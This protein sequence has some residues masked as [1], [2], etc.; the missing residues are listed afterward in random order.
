MELAI[1]SS[2]AL[3]SG[4]DRPA[5]W[6]WR[7][8]AAILLTA[9]VCC[10][11]LAD[12]MAQ[13]APAASE[14]LAQQAS[15]A[16]VV[17][18]NRPIV[19]FRSAIGSLTPEQRAERVQ[20]RL[21]D[22]DI[23]KL[24][25]EIV[26]ESGALGDVRGVLLLLDGGI[27][28]GITEGD[29]DPEKNE[30][31]EQVAAEATANL[32]EAFAARLEQER[33]P[34]L[35]RGIGLTLGGA[36]FVAALIWLVWRLRSRAG[37]MFDAL[38][39]RHVKAAS[40]GRFEW[41]RYGYEFTARM[42][43][44]VT[45]FAVLFLL[46]VW[47]AFSLRQFPLTSPLGERLDYYLVA[48]LDELG[49]NALDAV[50]GIL[51]VIIIL[52]FAQALSR[53]LGNVTGAVEDGKVS[54][55]FL[56]RDTARATRQILRFVIWAVAIAIAYPYIPGSDSPAFKGLS[57]LFGLMISLGSTGVVSQ[58]MG[59][60]VLAYSRALHPGDFV[61]VGSIEGTV[62][63]VGAISSKLLTPK[64]EEVTIPNSVLISDSITN[65]S[66]RL[67][68]S[69]SMLSTT[70]TIGYD[71]PWRQVHAML[72]AAAAQ[73]DGILG[74]P[75]PYV[76]QRALGD[77]YVQYELFVVVEWPGERAR[78]LSALLGR[79]QDEFNELGVQIMSP[80]FFDQPPQPVTVPKEKWFTPPAKE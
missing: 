33:L 18:M 69:A 5:R 6:F 12:D 75:A 20:R 72:L 14:Q 1:E 70:V 39:A 30:S 37:R 31:V 74:T 71:A 15:E 8:A 27:L 26:I 52:L 38:I 40:G 7:L 57:V 10:H 22:L 51:T 13:L 79:I 65:Y 77:F 17:Y 60:I 61:R 43:Q 21:R 11:A 29:V 54:L 47:L 59:G 67:S 44:L 45:T 56:Q 76:L 48:T 23:S 28:F 46:Y 9:S 34:V 41:E 4:A 66:Q 64:N 62:L 16:T 24:Q 25:H 55:P 78:A 35:L 80:H 19:T 49:G 58:I 2:A 50:P 36:L 32:K 68:D 73:V 63:R 3:R 53:V 42:V